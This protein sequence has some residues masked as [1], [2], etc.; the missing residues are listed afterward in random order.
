MK[1]SNR[2][3]TVKNQVS[4]KHQ[5]EKRNNTVKYEKLTPDI[6]NLYQFFGTGTQEQINCKDNL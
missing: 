6:A 1:N 2:Q 3:E 4:E 5:L